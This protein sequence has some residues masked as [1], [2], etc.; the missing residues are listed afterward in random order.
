MY[1]QELLNVNMFVVNH[2]LYANMFI[3]VYSGINFLHMSLGM[4]VPL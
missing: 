4:L 1:F 3:P 2:G